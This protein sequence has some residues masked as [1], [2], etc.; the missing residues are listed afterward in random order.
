MFCEK[1]SKPSILINIFLLIFSRNES[2]T[3]KKYNL[4]EKRPWVLFRD[5]LLPGPIERSCIGRR[6]IVMICPLKNDILRCCKFIF[7]KSAFV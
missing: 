5:Q 7:T 3:R 2:S 4:K 6:T 1:T